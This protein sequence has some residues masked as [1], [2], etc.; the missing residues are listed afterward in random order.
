LQTTAYHVIQSNGGIALTPF[1]CAYANNDQIPLK[2]AL[3]HFFESWKNHI[4]WPGCALRAAVEKNKDKNFK[5]ST[6]YN[7]FKAHACKTVD[8]IKKCFLCF[9]F[10]ELLHNEC[11]YGTKGIEEGSCDANEIE[12]SSDHSTDVPTPA[13]VC[14]W[15]TI[16]KF[17]ECGLFSKQ[18]KWS[19]PMCRLLDTD[20]LKY[21]AEDAIQYAIANPKSSGKRKW[22]NHK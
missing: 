22:Q 7:Y 11:K 19:Y 18:L 15:K 2:I 10:Q 17:F 3:C 4:T 20:L 16:N 6:A 1:Q 13:V 9:D 14:V 21:T 5:S 8:Q 12:H